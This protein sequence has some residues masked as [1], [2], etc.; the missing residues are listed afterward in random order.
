PEWPDF[1]A[2]ESTFPPVYQGR[3]GSSPATR[4]AYPVLIRFLRIRPPARSAPPR[5]PG[6]ALQR[7]TRPRPACGYR[8]RPPA[9]RSLFLAC[10]SGSARPPAFPVPFLFLRKAPGRAATC[11]PPVPEVAMDCEDRPAPV[12]LALFFNGGA[13]PGMACGYRDRRPCGA[14]PV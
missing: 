7:P 5:G 6:A 11:Y 14:P 8:G 4:A 3:A 10:S 9:P 2:I 1:L 12:D 13:V